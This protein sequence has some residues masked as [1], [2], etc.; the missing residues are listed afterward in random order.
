[1]KKTLLLALLPA[2][3]L[4]LASDRYWDGTDSTA[5]ADGG[6]GTWDTAALIWDDA[7][8]AGGP[9]NWSN[10]PADSAIFGGATGT[11]T[12]GAAIEAAGLTFTTT[13]Y[14]LAGN[15]LT[16]SGAPVVTVGAGLTATATTSLASAVNVGIAG[17]GVFSLNPTAGN[18]NGLTGG[19][20]V[21]GAGTMVEL[22]GNNLGGSSVGTG[23]LTIE[24]GAI[25]RAFSHNT[26]GNGS[27]TAL[28]PLVINGGTF[29]ADAYNHVNSITMSGGTLGVRSGVT[30][31]D[32]MDMKFRVVNPTVTTLA[33][34][35][36]ATISSI[37]SVGVPLTITTADGAA[38]TDLLVS[39]G[40]IG[41][42]SVTKEGPGTLTFST[43]KTYSGGTVVNGGVLDLTGGGGTGGTIRGTVTVNTGAMLRM[44]AQDVTGYGT[45]VDRLHTINVNGGTLH[46]NNA[47]NMTLGNA[48][49]NLTGGVITGIANSNLDFFQGS[50]ALNSLASATTSTVSG[51]KVSIRQASGLTIGV[52]DGAAAD[53]LV[54]SSL[55][56]SNGFPSAPLVKTGA[57]TLVLTNHNTITGG[58]TVNGGILRLDSTNA[59][60]S[61]VGPG[62]LTINAGATVETAVNSFGWNYQNNVVINGGTL[63]Q[64]NDAEGPDSHLRNVTL[65]AGT[66]TG[67][68]AAKLFNLHGDV[69]VNAAATSSSINT[70]QLNLAATA[71]VSASA[72]QTTFTVADG[73]A[74]TDLDVTSLMAGGSGLIKA[75][76]GVMRL[77]QNNT[78]SGGVTVNE[79]TLLLASTDD[80]TGTIRG[81]VT[82]NAGGTLD[83]TVRNS[84][85]YNAASISSLTINGGTVGGGDFDQHFY[86]NGV[87]A[88]IPVTMTGGTLLLGGAAS[89]SF[90]NQF[91]NAPITVTST[92]TTTAQILGVTTSAGMAIRDGST[93][94]FDVQNG[95]QDVDLLVDVIISENNG[96]A[97]VTKT[98]DG[99]LLLTR[100]NT[101]NGATTVSA[102]TLLINGTHTGAG[103]ITASAGATLGGSGIVGNVT[104][105]DGATLSPGNSAGHFSVNGLA[106]NP[107]S[108]MVFELGAPNLGQNAGSDFVVVR[109]M[110]TLHG[111][112]NISAIAGFGSPVYGDKWLL[113]TAA[114]G[115]ADNGVALGSTPALAGGLTF[116]LDASDG[117][118][119]FLSVVPEAGTGALA[120][121]GLLLLVLR[122]RK[123]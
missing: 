122:L 59:A 51:T 16:L 40:V 111:S 3:F 108:V 30:Q 24:A 114:N 121:L 45:G 117:Q 23:A 71:G 96:T 11:V 21:S 43:Q 56:V 29:E 109:D 9:F 53:D 118:S 92:S 70:A 13:G 79:G 91:R 18:N 82:V 83:W 17:G 31:V 42:S 123:K 25:V 67:V 103:M 78:F 106:L 75:G 33:A 86:H 80:G 113:M 107:T 64:I 116:E 72:T 20:T 112:I 93:Q 32:G 50:S 119:V 19:V 39:G 110:L 87:G 88:S 77:T 27:G 4:V 102:G 76:A 90:A 36:T 38:A 98:G 2:S 74:A 15:T 10:S 22:R 63:R 95:T 97:G 62:T 7:A 54:I 55:I 100:N 120:G 8:A 85:G 37:M 48:V 69:T 34:A 84:T 12:L 41:G 26:L 115:I 65:A 46:N 105:E 99:T 5:D 6:N 35:S 14:T 66:M 101:Y 49:I 60:N 61:V 47:I 52:A 1:M 44:T 81:A 89:G 68:D 57:G 73:A 28:A 94:T 104:L 58:T